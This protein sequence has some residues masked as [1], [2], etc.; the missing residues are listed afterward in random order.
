MD[1]Q[2]DCTYVFSI[3]TP[4]NF[5]AEP[6]K[7]HDRVSDVRDVCVVVEYEA[8]AELENKLRQPEIEAAPDFIKSDWT[9]KGSRHRSSAAYSA[10]LE[11]LMRA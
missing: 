5:C 9:R 11:S 1:T 2:F 7:H 10:I 6:L 4:I 3:G 8:N